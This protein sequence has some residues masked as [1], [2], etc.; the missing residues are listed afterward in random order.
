MQLRAALVLLLLVPA[1]ASA[2]ADALLLDCTDDERLSRTYAQ[3]DYR[4]ALEQLATDS[5]QYGNCR[6]VIR[7]AARA[8]A[9]DSADRGQRR[10]ERPG[11]VTP[12]LA[13]GPPQRTADEALT[14]ANPAERERVRE[15]QRGEAPP[16]TR[17]QS[18]SAG[19]DAQQPA[20]DARR[21]P[22]GGRSAGGG[23]ARSSAARETLK[24]SRRRRLRLR[25][26][27]EQGQSGVGTQGGR[28]EV[29]VER[30]HARVV[31]AM[32]SRGGQ[33]HVVCR[34]GG[35]GTRRCALTAPRSAAWGRG[36]RGLPPPRSAG[37]AR[38]R[39]RPA[40][41]RR[42]TRGHAGRGRRSAP[43][44]AG[45]ASRR[46]C[47]RTQHAPGRWTRGSPSYG[48]ARAPCP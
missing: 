40:P 42:R 10:A 45:R 20:D 23:T 6:E 21:R 39:G 2:S 4:K 5:D 26:C 28:L 8:A 33:P 34:P 3:A 15:L 19:G 31:D 35:R 12:A 7:N 43:D 47:A 11:T 18:R 30:S 37:S 13:G 22:R 41:S 48:C 27:Q 24:R 9:A 14:A 32:A 16:T 46:R 36:R 1:Q 38:C 25:C 44:W 29:E 17:A